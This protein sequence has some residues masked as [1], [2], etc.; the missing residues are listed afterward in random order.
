MKRLIMIEGIKNALDLGY[1]REVFFRALKKDM[2]MG[3]KE[4][5]ARLFRARGF[6]LLTPPGYEALALES[7]DLII[8]DLREK[9]QFDAGHL[10]GAVSHPFDDFLGDV[11]MAGQYRDKLS[12]P[13]VLICDTG[14]M[15]RV[16]ASILSET[17]FTKLHSIS[18]GMRRMNRWEHIKQVHRRSK[19]SRC[20]LC[21]ELFSA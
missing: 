20:P 4:F 10:P 5:I 12:S 1:F 15:S 16:A 13:V 6:S 21:H 17:G 3:P 19:N 2:E 8:V 18:R 14:H 9:R 7:S 11:L